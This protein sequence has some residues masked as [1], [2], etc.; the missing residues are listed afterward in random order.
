MVIIVCSW[1]VISLALREIAR[2]QYAQSIVVILCCLYVP[3]LIALLVIVFMAVGH[4]WIA[5][6]SVSGIIV[7]SILIGLEVAGA[8]SVRLP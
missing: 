6:I 7:L 2:K 8:I 1:L 3:S 5:L 4:S